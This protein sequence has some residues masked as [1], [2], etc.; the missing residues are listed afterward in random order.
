MLFAAVN[1]ARK[2]DVDPELALRAAADRF[3]ARVEQAA[4]IAARAGAD[5]RDIGPNAQLGY[6][7]QARLD[8]ARSSGTDATRSPAAGPSPDNPDHGGKT[9]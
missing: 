2:L 3:R 6:Y 8:E 1:V 9:T 5:W 7:A 4:A